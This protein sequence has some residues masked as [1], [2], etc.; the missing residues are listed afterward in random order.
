MK[1]DKRYFLYALDIGS[2]K[3]TLAAAGMSQPGVLNPIFIETCLSKGIFKGVV[4]DLAGLSDSV[5]Q[6]FRRMEARCGQK[7]THT[8][9][10]L[11]G[12]YINA[13]HSVA[14]VAL[15]ER[16]M[17]SITRRDIEKLNLQARMLGLELNEH[18]LHEFPQGYSVDRHNMILNPFG[19]HGRKFEM[20]LLLVSADTG[21]IENITKA[22]EQAGLDV[23]QLVFS[24]IAASAAVLSEEE[25]EKGAVLVDI[26]DALT[27]VL[28]FKD[29]AVR[30]LHVLS[31]GGRNLTE[32]IANYFKLTPELA[33]EVKESSLEIDNDIQEADE[34]MI[35]SDFVYRPIRKKELYSLILPEIEKFITTLKSVVLESGVDGIA[36]MPVV[37][38]GGLSLLGGL[39]EKMEH[40]LGMPV[41]MGLVKGS[42]DIPATKAPA[43][44]AA[45]GLLYMKRDSYQTNILK[46]QS[47]GKNKVGRMF[48]YLVNLYQD[49]F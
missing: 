2:K 30:R 34:V 11:N 46:I 32:V 6:I 47:Q 43:Y 13:R 39:L 33:E 36:G 7:A 14:A 5:Q 26:G 42:N 44:A 3:I 8:A 18:L 41:K 49:Y 28:V 19:L 38:T 15:A 48:D 9:V 4:N 12:N 1:K 10:S 20:D 45:I 17:R 35:K 22:I 16:G 23:R 25:K 40:D 31:F 24:G 21:Y 29:G 37:V 27:G